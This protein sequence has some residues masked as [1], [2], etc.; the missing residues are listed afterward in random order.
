[1]PTLPSRLLRHYQPSSSPDELFA[2]EQ[3]GEYYRRSFDESSRR[4]GQEASYPHLPVIFQQ[5]ARR[6]EPTV[7]Y[8]KSHS[9]SRSHPFPSF[10]GVGRKRSDS[11]NAKAR[12]AQVLIDDDEDDDDDDD[13][14]PQF[15]GTSSPGR[16]RNAPADPRRVEEKDTETGHCMTCSSQVKWSKGLKTFCCAVCMTFNDL[17]RWNR[18]ASVKERNDVA[19]AAAAAS[20]SVEQDITRSKSVRKRELT[21]ATSY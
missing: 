9:R 11:L 12:A 20:S 15:D 18:Y 6:A 16:R 7:N 1:M 14:A 8:N 21:Q 4:T 5:P 10:F 13:Y 17:E 2:D 3:V 19:A